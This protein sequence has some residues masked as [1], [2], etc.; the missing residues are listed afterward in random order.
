MAGYDLK[1]NYNGTGVFAKLWTAVVCGEYRTLYYP[2]RGQHA[3]HHTTKVYNVFGRV[4]QWLKVSFNTQWSLQGSPFFP[5][6][7]SYETDTTSA[8]KD[9]TLI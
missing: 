5:S 8:S 2:L 1:Y 6:L 3:H 4:P 7:Q 9:K